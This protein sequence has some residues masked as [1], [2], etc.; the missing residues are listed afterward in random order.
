MRIVQRD[1]HFNFY[2]KDYEGG[3]TPP[4]TLSKKKE[5]L[6]QMYYM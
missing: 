5:K 6:V 2:I 1:I 3:S 4:P